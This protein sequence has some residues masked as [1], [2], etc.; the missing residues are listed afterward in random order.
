MSKA[1][2]RQVDLYYRVVDGADDGLTIQK[3]VWLEDD[4]R[5]KEG[6]EITLKGDDDRRWTIVRLYNSVH[7][8]SEIK[9]TFDN[10]NYDVHKGLD[11]KR[12]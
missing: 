3:T 11:I 12:T 7:E 8:L 4:K 9:T 6:I 1:L 5:L 10:N 2:Y